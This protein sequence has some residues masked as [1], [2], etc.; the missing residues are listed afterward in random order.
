MNAMKSLEERKAEREARVASTASAKAARRESDM[1]VFYD[2]CETRG[3][4]DAIMVETDGR[5]IVIRKP[6]IAEIKRWRE[7]A[8]ADGR[9]A[10]IRKAEANIQLGRACVLHPPDY[11]EIVASKPAIEDVVA[12][13]AIEAAGLKLDEHGGK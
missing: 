7:A 10:N 5:V 13:A 9:G 4:D 1:H 12:L 3:D 11:Q 8:N 6:T 2:L